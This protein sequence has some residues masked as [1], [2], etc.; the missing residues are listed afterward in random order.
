VVIDEQTAT[1]LPEAFVQVNLVR[2]CLLRHDD[3][4]VPV[5]VPIVQDDA[6]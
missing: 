4:R 6:G 5:L 3:V 2:P 1:V